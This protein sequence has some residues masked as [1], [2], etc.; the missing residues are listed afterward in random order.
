MHEIDGDGNVVTIKLA[1][2]L[3]NI[4]GLLKEGT[5]IELSNFNTVIFTYS[6]NRK[7]KTS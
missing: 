3:N 4:S 1:T 6:E 7:G 2:Q 5:V